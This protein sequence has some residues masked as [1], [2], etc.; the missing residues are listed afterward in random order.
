VT[1]QS[2]DA[3]A[4]VARNQDFGTRQLFEVEA[5]HQRVEQR[6]AIVKHQRRN[7]AQ[8][9]E[10]VDGMRGV[11]CRHYRPRQFNTRAQAGFLKRHHNLVDKR[12]ARG[13]VQQHL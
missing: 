2:V 1:V 8:R 12:G 7:L 10:S 6:F 9:I 3:L 11:E 5:N 13:P 4:G